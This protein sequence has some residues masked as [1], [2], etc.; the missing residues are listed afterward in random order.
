MMADWLRLALFFAIMVAIVLGA[1]MIYIE[2][3]EE[4]SGIG[5]VV[6]IIYLFV[7]IFFIFFILGVLIPEA[8]A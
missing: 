8:Y 5:F 2:F 4:R 6:L 1:G 3:S 7:V